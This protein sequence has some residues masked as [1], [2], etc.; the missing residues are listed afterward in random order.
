MRGRVGAVGALAPW[1]RWRRGRVGAVAGW[2]V[3]EGGGP[4]T[5]WA[6]MSQRCVRGVFTFPLALAPQRT[7]HWSRYATKFCH[8]VN[9]EGKLAARR[10]C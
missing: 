2:A 4:S 6:Q 3:F 9:V 10:A 8:L 1:A 7:H 5:T